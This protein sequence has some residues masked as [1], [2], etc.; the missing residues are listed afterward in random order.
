MKK[1]K[2][3]MSL[4]SIVLVL[5]SCTSEKE[6]ALSYVEK[7][8]LKGYKPV[9]KIYVCLPNSV[10]HT[11]QTLNQIDDFVDLDYDVQDSVIVAN[12]KILNRINDSIFL[13]QFNDNLIYNLGRLGIP[14]EV[15]DDPILMPKAVKNKVFTL[16]ILQLEAEEFVK[17]TRSDYEDNKNNLYYYYDY[18]LKG[19]STNVWYL[20][21]DTVDGD[22]KDV[23]FKNFETIDEFEGTIKEIKGNKALGVGVFDKIDVNDA[24][25]M[26]YRAGAISAKK[27]CEKIINDYVRENVKGL[28]AYY[29]YFNPIDKTVTYYDYELYKDNESFIKIDKD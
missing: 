16:Y 20:L 9:E 24:Y 23:Y 7:F 4:L 11:N 10:L 12:T 22:N 21:N 17:R 8:S 18:D 1:I 19:F 28:P 26:A 25:L 6:L 5:A 2:N 14:V 3:I 27:F 29:Y 15:V 13:Q